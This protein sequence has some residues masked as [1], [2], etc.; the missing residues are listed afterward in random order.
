[1]LIVYD[2]SLIDSLWFGTFQSVSSIN[3]AGFTLT[4][5]SL[6]NFQS[7][8]LFQTYPDYKNDIDDILSNLG[9]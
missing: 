1:M 5:N 4:S 6:I 2:Y 8:Y 3:N 9:Y 7:D